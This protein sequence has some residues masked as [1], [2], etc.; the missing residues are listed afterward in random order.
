[1]AA[2]DYL[3]SQYYWPLPYLYWANT[4]LYWPIGFTFGLG[5]GRI[6]VVDTEDRNYIVDEG[7]RVWAVPIEN[8]ELVV[9]DGERI[10]VTPEEDREYVASS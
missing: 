8:R 1:M 7:D 5:D 9:E 10:W 6:Y 4:Y 3:P 2:N